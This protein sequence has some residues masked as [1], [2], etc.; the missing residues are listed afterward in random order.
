MS[1]GAYDLAPKRDSDSMETQKKITTPT[2]VVIRDDGKEIEIETKMLANHL[3][4][5]FKLKTVAETVKKAVKK[6]TKRA[7]KKADK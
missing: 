7:T 6:V 3:D 5:G 4:R 1:L 2:V